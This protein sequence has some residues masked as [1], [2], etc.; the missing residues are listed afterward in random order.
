MLDPLMLPSTSL[1]APEG[2][3]RCIGTQLL[4]SSGVPV[5]GSGSR[6]VTFRLW[7]AHTSAPSVPKA[8]SNSAVLLIPQGVRL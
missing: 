8:A 2:T 1:K 6:Q 7:G 3:C 4:G 5:S